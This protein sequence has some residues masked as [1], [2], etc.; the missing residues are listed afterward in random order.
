MGSYELFMI[1]EFTIAQITRYL[2]M[3]SAL[4]SVHEA[5]RENEDAKKRL[6]GMTTIPYTDDPLGSNPSRPSIPIFQT[7]LLPFGHSPRSAVWPRF[8]R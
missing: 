3:K 5:K 4:F 7:L 1:Y 2:L 8:Q 6:D